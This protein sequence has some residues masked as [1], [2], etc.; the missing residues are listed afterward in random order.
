MPGPFDDA[1]ANYL[2]LAN[3]EGRL[4]LWPQRISVPDGWT[5]VAGG[6]SLDAAMT[7]VDELWAS[8]TARLDLRG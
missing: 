4:S 8:P 3:D 6:L 2:I 1:E 5:R 7:K